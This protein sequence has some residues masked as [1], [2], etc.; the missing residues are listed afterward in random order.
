[1][2]VEQFMIAETDL[3]TMPKINTTGMRVMTYDQA[4]SKQEMKELV[5][6]TRAA[7]SNNFL[8]S[9]ESFLVYYDCLMTFCHKMLR[10]KAAVQAMKV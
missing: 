6:D 7:I 9:L 1:M 2:C 5:R 8:G 3:D 10:D 4:Y